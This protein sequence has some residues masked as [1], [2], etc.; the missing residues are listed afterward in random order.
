MPFTTLCTACTYRLTTNCFIFLLQLLFL[1]G[2]IGI[3]RSNHQHHQH[4]K[5]S[6]IDHQNLSTLNLS[7]SETLP[8]DGFRLELLELFAALFRSSSN[9]KP[10]TTDRRRPKAMAQRRRDPRFFGDSAPLALQEEP[11]HG[12]DMNARH[13]P[14]HF[15]RVR[16]RDEE[17]RLL[18]EELRAEFVR[19]SISNDPTTDVTHRFR[20][21]TY[22]TMPRPFE[23]YSCMSPSYQ[24][25]W[26]FLQQMYIAPK[27]FTEA[28]DTP[29]TRHSQI[30][31]IFCASFCVSMLE[32][33]VEAGI[34]V[35]FKYI[36]GCGDRVLRHGFNETAAQLYRLNQV[37]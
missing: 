3:V 4:Q 34:F 11:E 20:K 29:I 32:A 30:P 17:E 12:S 19:V 27:A 35:G 13:A 22:A 16:T 2:A 6:V 25:K 24:P 37:I 5:H 9:D 1:F 10:A 14:A 7:M 23:C 28:C 31:T 15:A 8:D 26:Q 33:N 18:E 36:R 21:K